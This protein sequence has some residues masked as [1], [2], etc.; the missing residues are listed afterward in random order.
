MHGNN[1]YEEKRKTNLKYTM[2]APKNDSPNK[3]LAKVVIFSQDQLLL[4]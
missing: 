1:I 2:L 3:P 4:F